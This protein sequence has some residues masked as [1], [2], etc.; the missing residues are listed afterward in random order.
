MPDS[1]S[2]M[3]VPC[4]ISTFVFVCVYM[5]EFQLRRRAFE[6]NLQEGSS[7][8]QDDILILALPAL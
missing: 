2:G 7:L 8:L 5:G 1:C 3:G 6:G 4:L